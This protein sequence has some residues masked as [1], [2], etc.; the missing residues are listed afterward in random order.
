MIHVLT[1][2]GKGKT[3]SSIGMAVRA[4]G[5]KWSVVFVQ[6][7]KNGSS[8]EI[9]ILK[10]ISNVRL[11]HANNDYGFISQMTNE[12]KESLKR[13]YAIIV[14]SLIDSSANMIIL[15][16][17][18]HV[19]NAGF[20]SKS[21]LEKLIHESDAELVF[22]GRNA[23]KWIMEIANYVSIIERYKHP[24]DEGIAA[25]IGIEY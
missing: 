7:L 23:P 18:T 22:T 10:N 15:D 19:L 25:R 14:D 3:T 21:K 11:I 8:G 4:A 16:E 20:I 9:E 6:F 1:G 24:F 5:H 13:E 12:Q 17:I 2:D